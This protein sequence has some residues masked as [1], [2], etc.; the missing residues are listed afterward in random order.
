MSEN[1]YYWVQWFGENILEN[2]EDKVVLLSNKRDVSKI[3]DCFC[4]IQI[5]H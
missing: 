3:I 5:V 2:Y 1:T 4:G